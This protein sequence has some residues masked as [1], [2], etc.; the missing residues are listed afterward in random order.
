MSKRTDFCSPGC[1]CERDHGEVV[2]LRLLPEVRRWYGKPIDIHNTGDLVVALNR[3][4]QE[5]KGES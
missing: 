2:C 3:L 1:T 4:W 5:T